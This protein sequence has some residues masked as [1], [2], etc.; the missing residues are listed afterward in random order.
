MTTE[1]TQAEWLEI[2]SRAKQELPT[3]PTV[4]HAPNAGSPSFAKTIDHTL[5][6]LDATERQVDLLCDEAIK[7]EFKVSPYIPEDDIAA[8]IP[9]FE[10]RCQDGD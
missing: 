4:H 8:S 1:Y 6:K 7:N 3:T 9:F 5:L 10:G 2:F